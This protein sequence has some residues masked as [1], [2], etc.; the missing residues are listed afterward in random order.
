VAL[1]LSIAGLVRDKRKLLAIAAMLISASFT[2]FIL[3]ARWQVLSIISA[4]GR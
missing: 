4:L 2:I 1:G 3:T